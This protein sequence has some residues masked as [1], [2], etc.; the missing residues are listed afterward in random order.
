MTIFRI[1]L[2][3]GLLA[4]APAIA[5]NL[6]GLN[7]DSP[8]TLTDLHSTMGVDWTPP[9]RF[10]N[11]EPLAAPGTYR[12]FTQLVGCYVQTVVTLDAAS[13]V[14][15]IGLSFSS[16]C[17][18]KIEA[19]AIGK[20]G[21]PTKTSTATESTL[22]GVTVQNVEH[23]WAMPENASIA[24]L[25]YGTTIERGSLE[26]ETAAHATMVHGLLNAGGKL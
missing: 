24:L 25:K 21:T 17:F 5:V 12:G 3:L 22:F 2:I 18:D 8:A 6:A 14:S 20:W 23:D 4:T 19:A 1:A 10:V 9:K 26:I 11:P 15:L 16:T 13:R 7:L